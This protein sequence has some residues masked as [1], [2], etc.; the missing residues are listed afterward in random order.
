ANMPMHPALMPVYDVDLHK[1]KP[2]IAMK[3]VEGASLRGRFRKERRLS[4]EQVCNI[5]HCLAGGL[6]LL[7]EQGLVHGDINMGNVLIDANDNCILTDFHMTAVAELTTSV[8]EQELP[9][10]YLPA[11][12]PE[13]WNRDPLGP[14]SDVYQFGMLLYELLTGQRPFAEVPQ[15]ELHDAV[16][17]LLPPRVSEVVEDLPRQFDPIFVKALAK[18]PMERYASVGE[19]VQALRGAWQSYAFET[20][21]YEGEKHHGAKEWDKAIEAYKKAS[22]LRPDNQIVNEALKRAERRKQDEI[23]LAK[24]RQ[25][26]EKEHWR[27]AENHL[28][29]VSETRERK[30]LQDLV[31][32]KIQVEL[33]YSQGKVAMHQQEL[34]EAQTLLD[35][36]DALEPGYKDVNSLLGQLAEEIESYFRQARQA[37]ANNDTDRALALLEPVADHETAVTIRREIAQK[38]REPVGMAVS[39]TASINWKPIAGVALI[40]VFALAIVFAVNQIS[41]NQTPDVTAQPTT[42]ATEAVEVEVEETAP[43]VE[44]TAVPTTIPTPSIVDLENCLAEKNVQILLN[45]RQYSGND[46]IVLLREV[47]DFEIELGTGGC[48]IPSNRLRYRLVTVTEPAP[49]FQDAPIL[50]YQPPTDVLS[51]IALVNLMIEGGDYVRSIALNLNFD[52]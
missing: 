32:R 17:H 47:V 19:F 42:N 7:H 26:I 21:V 23:A 33:L 30:L 52:E 9:L 25:S 37:M 48:E 41:E 15:A 16:T 31:Q 39:N 44:E 46:S 45:G 22:E 35:Q 8:L 29:Q 13:G 6:D 36:A 10:A 3:F 51:D 34:L 27:E 38:G 24:A 2:F 49:P 1:G 20:Y 28:S 4:I 43:V 12:P 40:I 11:I 50:S 14:Q 5:A 18:Q